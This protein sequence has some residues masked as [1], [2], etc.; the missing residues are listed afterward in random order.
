MI[1]LIAEFASP[2]IYRA[3]VFA[4]IS[5][6][7]AIYNAVIN[8]KRFSYV[9]ILVAILILAAAI[10]FPPSVPTGPAPE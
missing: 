7:V 5:V 4:L 3:L 6:A 8:R 2:A 10:A 9:L 1:F